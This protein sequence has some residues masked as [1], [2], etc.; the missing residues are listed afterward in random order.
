MVCYRENFIFY[1]V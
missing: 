1:G